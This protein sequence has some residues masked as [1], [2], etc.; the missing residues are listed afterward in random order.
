[1]FIIAIIGLFVPVIFFNILAYIV[2][3]HAVA[4]F[5]TL[6]CFHKYTSL[7]VALVLALMVFLGW[8]GI[9]MIMLLGITMLADILI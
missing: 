2:I 3:I 8:E 4:R 9:R 5:F 7:P 1:M 6:R